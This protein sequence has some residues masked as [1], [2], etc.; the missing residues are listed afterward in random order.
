MKIAMLG[1]RESAELA[2]QLEARGHQVVIYRR[3]QFVGMLFAAIHAARVT[4]PDIAVFFGV[5]GSPLCLITRVASIPTVIH[6]GGGEDIDSYEQLLEAV[7]VAGG[8]GRLPDHVLDLDLDLDL[9][10]DAGALQAA[11]SAAVER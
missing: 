5:A 8:P 1:A 3:P 4:R 2:A 11:A 6:P 7:R 9:N 10:L